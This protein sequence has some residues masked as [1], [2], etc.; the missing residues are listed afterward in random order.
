MVWN[1][2]TISPSVKTQRP[3]IFELV[4]PRLHKV[5]FVH[6]DVALSRVKTHASDLSVLAKLCHPQWE[7]VNVYKELLYRM[8]IYST[9]CKMY[10]SLYTNCC[11]IWWDL[12]LRE[13]SLFS[14]HVWLLLHAVGSSLTPSAESGVSL[15]GLLSIKK[16]FVHTHQRTSNHLAQSGRPVRELTD[17]ACVQFFVQ[18]SP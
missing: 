17:H 9:F 15:S 13:S 10:N 4:V 12:C 3:G 18:A 5:V 11:E 1:G 16:T 8:F 6:A 2:T 14:R 7:H